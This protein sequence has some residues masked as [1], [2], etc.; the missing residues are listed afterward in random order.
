MANHLP[1]WNDLPAECKEAMTTAA[2]WFT[3]DWSAGQCALDIYIKLQQ[4][5]PAPSFPLF[6]TT[7]PEARNE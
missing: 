1:D 7:R 6:D 2:S 5:L 4:T 3:D